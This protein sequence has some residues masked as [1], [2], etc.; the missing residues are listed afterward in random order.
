[1]SRPI[2]VTLALLAGCGPQTGTRLAPLGSRSALVGRELQVL[3]HADTSDPNVQFSYDSDIADLATRRLKPE[4]ASYAGGDALF[5]WTP[6]A[7][8]VGVHVIRFAAQ[9]EGTFATATLEVT[10][11]AGQEPIAFRQPVGDG[12][13]LDLARAP[14]VDVPI[15]VEDSTVT[16][17]TLGQ[18]EPW[19]AGGYVEQSGPL[20]GKLRFCPTAA[21]AKQSSIFPFA[22]VASDKRGQRAEKRYVIVLGG[23]P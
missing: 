13:T 11:Q 14:C 7:D 8:D 19:S 5:R 17:V 18:G 22:L 2:L 20:T 16:E 10:V 4:I 3:L 12:T 1:V 15:L 23:V 9:L 21:Q 6:L